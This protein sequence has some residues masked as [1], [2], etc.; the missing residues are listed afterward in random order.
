MDGWMDGY[1]ALYIYDE[2]GWMDIGPYRYVC[3]YVCMHACMHT[4]IHTYSMQI[5][6]IIGSM[7]PPDWC[8]LKVV[9][10]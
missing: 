8:E 5:L 6:N 3:M 10:I 4:Y 7:L 2:Y 9:D 1:R